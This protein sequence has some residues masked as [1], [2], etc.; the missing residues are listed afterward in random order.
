MNPIALVRPAVEKRRSQPI[1]QVY[2]RLASSRAEEPAA[3]GF[4]RCTPFT[5]GNSRSSS[6]ASRSSSSTVVAAP[7][8]RDS[9]TR[10][11][12]IEVDELIGS[13]GNRDQR[14][15]HDRRHGSRRAGALEERPVE[16]PAALEPLAQ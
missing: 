11:S 7:P 3:R 10:R 13:P 1:D 16:Q 4:W 14:Q 15:Q 12:E 5:T 6:S 8:Q 9:Q 2:G